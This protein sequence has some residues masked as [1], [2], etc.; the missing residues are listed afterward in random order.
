MEILDGENS[1]PQ[2]NR[3]AC[4]LKKFWQTVPQRPCKYTSKR[5]QLFKCCCHAV[6]VHVNRRADAVLEIAAAHDHGVGGVPGV[7][8]GMD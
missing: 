5:P 3:P 2:T 8:G 7:V 4:K 1:W 6:A